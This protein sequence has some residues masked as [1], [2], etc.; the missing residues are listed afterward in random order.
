MNGLATFSREYA[1]DMTANGWSGR[2][3][4]RLE[5][6]AS[7][8]APFGDALIAADN[9]GLALLRL[10]RTELAIHGYRRDE[11]NFPTSL[12][13]LVPAWLNEVPLDPFSGQAL[14]YRADAEGYLLYSVGNDGTDDGGILDECIG[15][16]PGTD[17]SLESCRLQSIASQ[18][19]QPQA[20]ASPPAQAQAPD[21]KL[22]P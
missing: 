12:Q 13:T 8:K 21:A 19:W 5:D 18:Q 22:A 9:R 16:T 1:W 17:F 15:M 14:V 3:H 11:G 2:L 10:V 7:G 20:A 4:R 6:V